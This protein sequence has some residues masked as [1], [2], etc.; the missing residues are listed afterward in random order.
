MLQR[1]LQNH[2]R[3]QLSQ[4]ETG[5]RQVLALNAKHPDALH[6]LGVIALQARRHDAALKLIDQAIEIKADNAD[7]HLN[8][9]LALIG[10][11]Q[12]DAALASVQRAIELRPDF[13]AAHFN[14]GNI[15]LALGEAQ[16]AIESY[17]RAIENNAGHA[18]AYNNLGNALKATGKLDQA[19]SNYRRAI[20]LNPRHGAARNNLGNFLQATG[21][22]T[23]AR[24]QFEQALA[25]Q[26]NDLAIKS[27]L[28]A[29]WL[30]T[31]D[32]NRAVAAFKEVAQHNP[33]A[34]Q[35][36]YNLGNALRA[37]GQIE[38]AIA[39]YRRAT[40]LQPEQPQMHNNLGV[41]LLAAGQ[42]GAA[43]AAF[44]RALDLAPDYPQALDN[45]IDS[46]LR[47]CD[48]RQLDAVRQTLLAPVL[49]GTAAAEHPP[50]PFLVARL[51][52]VVSPAELQS[53]AR[54]TVQHR[55]RGLTVPPRA[56]RTSSSQAGLLHIGYVST[57]FNNHATSHL[58]HEL[59]GLHDRE[60]FSVTGYSLGHDDDSA[61]RRRI[62]TGCDQFRD[63]Q[64]WQSD[65]IATQIAEDR[66]DLLVDLNGHSAENRIELFALRPAPVQITYLAYPGTTGAA[67]FDYLIG[68]ALVTPLSDQA[69]YDECLL[70]M[71]HCYQI[72]SARPRA[73][74][75]PT[76][77]DCGLPP[78]AIVFCCF[79]NNFKIEPK[80]FDVWCAILRQVPQS[81]LWLLSGP[82]E[83]ENNLRS[84][85]VAREIDPSRLIF[86]P[87]LPRADHLARQRLADLFLDTHFYNAH[88]TGSDALWAG[89]PLLTCP[90]LS[91][92]SRVGASLVRAAGIAELAV[93]DLSEYQQTAVQLAND[94]ARLAEL[95][96]RLAGN[97]DS[98][99]LFDT[100]RFVSTLE[101][102]Y[103]TVWQRHCSGEAPQAVTLSD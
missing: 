73:V 32:I 27:N 12:A 74:A 65:A 38:L 92:A 26:P 18:D 29:V 33:D 71:P 28:A 66:I 101:R 81:V 48:W 23:E 5:Y 22:W 91:F 15:E 40:E 86:A 31:G 16:A 36:H 3:G 62:Q 103:E 82:D 14:R 55:T 80:I 57:D 45:L 102:G 56:Q 19:A 93:A 79:N 76:R 83:T 4:A 96:A 37:R 59:F 30:E 54:A 51:P 90:G 68:D 20:E 25:L 7:Y 50:R 53:V 21:R 41:A 60:R 39:G 87:H 35:A 46:Q 100:Q 69:F 64:Y 77:A 88:T 72:N 85:C 61:A 24:E 63:L 97:H 6:M 75:E 99:P 84:A 13:A 43:Q 98:C 1:A 11:N 52:V 89:L 58:T 95:K 47:L 49:A 44:Q 78:E 17:C 9:A 42:P 8:R 94:T 67:F 34:A 70:L 10:L 2:H